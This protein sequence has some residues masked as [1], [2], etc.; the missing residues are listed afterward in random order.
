MGHH[1]VFMYMTDCRWSDRES[2][3]MRTH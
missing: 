2:F 3:A 1:T